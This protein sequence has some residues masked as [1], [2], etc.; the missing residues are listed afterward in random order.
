MS[1]DWGLYTAMRGQDNWQQRRADKAMN[2]QLL[3]KQTQIEQ[4]KTAAEAQAEQSLNE[5]FNEL[6]NMEFLA[7]DQ[8]R[9]NAMERDARRNVIKGIAS[10]NGD[11]DPAVISSFASS[12]PV[13]D[14]RFLRKAYKQLVPD[15]Y[16]SVNF[17]CS[18]C[19]HEQGLEV[20]ITA[21]F[22][23]AE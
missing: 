13:R 2:L 19:G 1:L 16:M 22:C 11:S 18:H 15:V 3:E 8:E 17:Q 6:Q 7:E 9:V 5:Y 21:N 23:W 12:L 20:P 14:S 10:V 4:Q